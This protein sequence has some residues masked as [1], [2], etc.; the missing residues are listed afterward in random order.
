MSWKSN[1]LWSSC[2][3]VRAL[4]LTCA[5]FFVSLAP[6]PANAGIWE[7]GASGSYRRQNIDV[8]AVDESQSITGSLSYYLDEASAI[9][10]SYTDGIS[11]RTI[12]PTVVNG[13]ITTATYKALGLDFVYTLGSGSTRPYVKAGAQYLLEKKIVDQYL[14][15][16]GNF[17]AKTSESSPSL[18]P[19]VGVG[20]KMGLT[21]TIS[22]KAGIDAWTSASLSVQPIKIDYAGRVG[23]SWMF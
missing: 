14:D 18:V 7:I 20:F 23:L 16:T 2:A 19:S 6:L 15:N 9:E 21:T 11:K 17:Q 12:N 5:Y 10:L 3:L 22:L 1:S 13:H 8:D 4:A